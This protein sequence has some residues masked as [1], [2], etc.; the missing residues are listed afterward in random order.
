MSLVKSYNHWPGGIPSYIGRSEKPVDDFEPA[1]HGWRH[2]VREQWTAGGDEYQQ[3]R[4]LI[5]QW[6][7]AD[8]DFRDVRLRVSLL[9]R[10]I[11]AIFSK[12]PH[13]RSRAINPKRRRIS[14]VSK[15]ARMHETHHFMFYNHLP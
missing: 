14:R 9:T 7:T 10:D 12:N 8:Q 5:E 3:R 13:Y 15:T 6:A 1:T 4:T 2:F 11:K